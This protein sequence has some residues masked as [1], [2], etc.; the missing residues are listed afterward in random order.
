VCSSDLP[1]NDLNNL[2]NLLVGSEGTL[3]YSTAI[4][5]KLSPIIKNKVLGVCHFPTF[6]SAMDATQHLV[7]LGAYGVELVDATMISLARDI[8]LFRP[9]IEQ[10]VRGNP[11]ALLLVEFGE[12]DHSDN[13]KKL[14]ELEEAMGDLGFSWKG[15]GKRRGGV[16]PIVDAGLQNALVEVRKAG[17]NI[18][19]SM[20]DQGKPVSFVEDCAVELPDLA[21]YTDG[22]TEIFA[23][24]GAKGTWYAHASV[25][26]L[27]VRPVLN[28]RQEA[29][30]KTM[31]EIAEEAFELVH[32]YKGSHSGEHG[33]GIVRS[34][35]HERM[36]GPKIVRAFEQVKQRFEIGRAS[37]RERV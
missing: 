37:C 30:V 16:V 2:S 3:A 24:H 32:K 12:N 14:D 26:C 7:K 35:F 15:E 23:K 20:K 17:L 36:F 6:H 13:L 9:T 34:E 19:M 8:E 4:E 1:S 11:E 21:N 25:G 28:L 27:H 22:L 31:R 29:D 10:V 18:M 33:D 5:L